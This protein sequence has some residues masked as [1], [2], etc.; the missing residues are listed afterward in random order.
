MAILGATL[1][2]SIVT[3]QDGQLD[4]LE[5]FQTIVAVRDPS[6]TPDFPLGSF[7]IADC[8]FVVRIEWEDGSSQESASCTLSDAPLE[9]PEN[10]GTPPSEPLVISG[11]ECAW[12]SDCAWVTSE[13]EV[14]ASEFENG[15]SAQRSGLHVG[16]VPGRADRMPRGGAR[17][18][19]GSRVAGSRGTGVLAQRLTPGAGFAGD[20]GAR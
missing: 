5:D 12:I 20:G 18:V 2:P 10:Q 13:A 3:A 4:V 9:N 8:A 16:S 1:V 17:R 6:S 14:V 15:R 7:M 19:A 11:G